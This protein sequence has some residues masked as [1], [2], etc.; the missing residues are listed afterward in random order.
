MEFGCDQLGDGRQDCTSAFERAIAQLPSGSVLGVPA[1]NYRLTRPLYIDSKRVS[2]VGAGR[3]VTTI[4]YEIAPA[5]RGKPAF[6][7]WGRFLRRG[8]DS[9]E[10]TAIRGNPLRGATVLQVCVWHQCVKALPISLPD[11]VSV[12]SVR[13]F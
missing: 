10:L 9:T 11:W 12:W 13:S 6:T 8:G 7:Y 2:I 4:S 5:D 1:G 3:D